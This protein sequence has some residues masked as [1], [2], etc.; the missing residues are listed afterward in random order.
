MSFRLI[1]EKFEDEMGGESLANKGVG[2]VR[3]NITFFACESLLGMAKNVKIVVTR[4]MAL[5]P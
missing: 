4:Q 3:S 1:S 2:S 5:H